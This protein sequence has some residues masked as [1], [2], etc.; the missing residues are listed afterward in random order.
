MNKFCLL[1][2]SLI[3]VNSGFAED[4]EIDPIPLKSE[5][6]SLAEGLE[7]KAF[8]EE[9][10]LADQEEQKTETSFS[11]TNNPSRHLRMQPLK[12][13]IIGCPEVTSGH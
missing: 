3:L 6:F 9:K 11:Q 10:E 8:E 2:I 12:H 13:K 7:V 5:N 4:S 1:P